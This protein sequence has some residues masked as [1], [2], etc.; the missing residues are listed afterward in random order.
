MKR[1][2]PPKRLLPSWTTLIVAVSAL[3]LALAIGIPLRVA[4]N[5][6]VA[7]EECFARMQ[8]LSDAM[9]QA[10]KE[11]GSIPQSLSEGG[12]LARGE[13]VLCPHPQGPDP[14]YVYVLPTFA[15]DRRQRPEDGTTVAYCIEHLKFDGKGGFEVP[16][17]GTVNYAA[18]PNKAF[19]LEASK[20]ERWL[21]REGKWERIDETGT[22]PKF[23]EVWRFPDAPWPP[24]LVK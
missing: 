21:W 16:L 2:R 15:P 3:A 22:L 14:Q 23:P 24:K 8:R 17:Q 5:R 11:T 10:A 9:F 6:R 12:A 19:Q 13:V 18:Y 4:R 20:L 1:R 7:I